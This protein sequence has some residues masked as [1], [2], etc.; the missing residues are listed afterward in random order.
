MLNQ[1]R[2]E[3]MS[4]KTVN[5]VKGRK[6]LRTGRVRAKA[7]RRALGRQLADEPGRRID[8]PATTKTRL[9]AVP[10]GTY[11]IVFFTDQIFRR[12]DLRPKLVGEQQRWRVRRV[13]RLSN[14]EGCGEQANRK[15]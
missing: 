8:R 3:V 11:A 13:N 1:K 10:K 9:P 5:F 6:A 7:R 4:M 12:I 14:S 2:E 15:P